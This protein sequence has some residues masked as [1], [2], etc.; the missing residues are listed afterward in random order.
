MSLLDVRTLCVD[1]S[2]R[3]D[4]VVDT[5]AYVD[6]GMDFFI[7]AGR[8]FLDSFVNTEN[9]PGIFSGT[10]VI[11][12]NTFNFAGCRSILDMWL[13]DATGERVNPKRITYEQFIENYLDNPSTADTGEPIVWAPNII[14]TP[15]TPVEANNL[16]KG[17]ILSPAVDYAYPIRIQGLFF[18]EALSVDADENYWTQMYPDILAYAALYKLEI[19]YRNTAGKKD[20]LDSLNE[21]LLGIDFDIANE[22]ASGRSQMVG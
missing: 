15:D 16:L 11:G 4:L 10:L 2:G 17:I 6:A 9:A 13:L 20:W 21:A 8:K 1:W 12:D 3:T 22:V 19:S 7:E 5:T 18:T 14:R